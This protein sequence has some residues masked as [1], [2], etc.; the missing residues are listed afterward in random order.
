MLTNLKKGDI[1]TF[2]RRRVRLT[3]GT[4]EARPI[5]WIVMEVYE[6]D[7]EALLISRW[8][9]DVEE[10]SLTEE[11]EDAWEGSF[12]RWMLNDPEDSFSCYRKWF[13]DEE[14]TQI[15]PWEWVGD[16]LFLPPR[17]MIK[18]AF[19]TDEARAAR[20]QPGEVI[21]WWDRYG[22]H[23][24][25]GAFPYWLR[26]SGDDGCFCAI[27]ESGELEEDGFSRDTHCGIRPM[28]YVKFEEEAP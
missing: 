11:P 6:G 10:N 23:D 28:M 12:I 18:S 22:K 27:L 1:V 16:C 8:L 20:V 21:S 9:T 13:T 3:N 15:T 19:P 7:R 2:G 17:H 4:R 24:A 25:T 5:E 26:D 14:R